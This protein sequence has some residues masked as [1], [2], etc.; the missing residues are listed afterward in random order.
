MHK[1]AGSLVVPTLV[2]QSYRFAAVG[3]LSTLVNYGFNQ[4]MVAAFGQ[5]WVSS[6][7]GYLAGVAVGYPLNRKWSFKSYRQERPSVLRYLCVYLFTFLLNSVLADLAHVQLVE[8][9][10]DFEIFHMEYLYYLPVI[11]VTT[12]L[13]FLGCKL[14]V[15][16][17]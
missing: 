8:R 10:T 5:P 1:E 12:I 11:V 4:G 7:I 17:G 2:T 15:F 13:N 6:A 16:R 14:F 9:W 3:S